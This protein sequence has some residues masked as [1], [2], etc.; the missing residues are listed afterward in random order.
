MESSQ[1][2]NKKRKRDGKGRG[3]EDYIGVAPFPVGLIGPVTYVEIAC[4]YNGLNKNR[5]KNNKR[6]NMY[7]SLSRS[8]SQQRH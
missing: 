5:N 4:P 1:S 2:L 3:R 7:R 6:N 8:E